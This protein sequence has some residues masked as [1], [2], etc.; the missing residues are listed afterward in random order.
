MKPFTKA[1]LAVLF[2]GIGSGLTALLLL[3]RPPVDTPATNSKVSTEHSVQIPPKETF[4]FASS[5]P[6]IQ[7]QDALISNIDHGRLMQKQIELNRQS[8]DL[9]IRE[10]EIERVARI[11]ERQRLKEEEKARKQAEEE[12]RLI[13]RKLEIQELEIQRKRELVRREQEYFEKRQRSERLR[14]EAQLR[15]EQRRKE[16]QRREEHAYRES[17]KET[18]HQRLVLLHAQHQRIATLKNRQKE[19]Q[20]RKER[21]QNNRQSTDNKHLQNPGN[22][23]RK[24]QQRE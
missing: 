15:E 18:E 14:L 8:I 12:A 11:Q 2:I 20:L 21:A 4:F 19:A 13:A 22:R 7:E 9:G 16:E 10:A 24:R 3:S 17:K 23:P 5:L 6:G 1:G